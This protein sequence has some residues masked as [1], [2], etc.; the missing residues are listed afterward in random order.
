MPRASC[1][2]TVYEAHVGDVVLTI[3]VDDS[4]LTVTPRSR[5]RRADLAFAAGP[6]IRRIISGELSPE[7]AIAGGVV[8]V[9]RGDPALL[10][11]F[12]QTFHLEPKPVAAVG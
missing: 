5:P 3:R 6:S 1:P 2:P 7:A 11:R 4:G 9:L 8:R 10:D 12:A